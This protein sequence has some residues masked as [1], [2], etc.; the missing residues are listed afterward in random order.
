MA[1]PKKQGSVRALFCSSAY[2]YVTF[3]AMSA[4]KRNHIHNPIGPLLDLNVSVRPED[5]DAA[6]RERWGNLAKNV[7]P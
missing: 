4:G 1:S 7:E 5:I 2:S 6:R 3:A